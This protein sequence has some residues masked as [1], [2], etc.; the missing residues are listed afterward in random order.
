MKFSAKK[1][2]KVV[3]L[4]SLM[5]MLSLPI[6]A[7]PVDASGEI[8]NSTVKTAISY[9]VMPNGVRLIHMM[10]D[11][12]DV[13]E[14]LENIK[15]T[16]ESSAL[17]SLFLISSLNDPRNTEAHLF[18]EPNKKA[19]AFLERLQYEGNPELVK[20]KETELKQNGYTI[21]G[22]VEYS[23]DIVPSWAKVIAIKVSET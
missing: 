14:E 16:L 11:H 5:A 21:E 1:I 19:N 6:V 22:Y 2:V 3:V 18:V 7:N 15:G 20:E 12:N 13:I 23:G 8:I 4:G 9:K 17:K 10:G